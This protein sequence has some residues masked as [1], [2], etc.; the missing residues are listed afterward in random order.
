MNPPGSTERTTLGRKPQR[1]QT[2]WSLVH[3]VLDA[4]LVCTVSF[5]AGG[6]YPVTL[7]TGYVRD[8]QHLILHGKKDSMLMTRVAAG[9]ALCVTVTQIDALVLA[10]SAF[11]HSVN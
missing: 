5:V 3:A 11:S 10:R 8:G 4:N 1:S 6:G 9:D 7:A 2:D